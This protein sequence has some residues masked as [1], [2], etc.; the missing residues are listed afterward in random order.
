MNVGGHQN[1]PPRPEK[2]FRAPGIIHKTLGKNDVQKNHAFKGVPE[3]L[4]S[5]FT[6]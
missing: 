3:A 5:T 2:E 4:P 1:L 6:P